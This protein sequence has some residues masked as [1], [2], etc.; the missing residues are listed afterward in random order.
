ME[1][2]CYKCGHIVEE[3]KPFCPQC[4]APQIRVAVSE[5][6][7]SASGNPSISSAPVDLP[8]VSNPQYTAASPDSLEWSR[9]LKSCAIAALISVVVMCLRLIFPLVAM[10]GAGVLSTVFYIRRNPAWRVN[11][12]SGAKLGAVT[13]LIIAGVCG[14]FLAITVAILQSSA[15]RNE[16]LDALQQVASRSND[17][18][19]QAALEL[20]KQPEGLGAKLIVGMVSFL[21]ISVGVSSLAGAVTGAFLGRRNRL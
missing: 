14:F 6:S 15:L 7:G 12:R 17:A 19:V 10:L 1:Y 2:P 13:G 3:G 21:V 9:A 20:L 11:A 5:P 18:Q 8:A 4:G 16:M